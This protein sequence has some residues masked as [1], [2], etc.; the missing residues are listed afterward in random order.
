MRIAL[1]AAGLFLAG[2]GLFAH[3]QDFPTVKSGQWTGK[4]TSEYSG[5]SNYS[6]TSS[7]LQCLTGDE[8]KLDPTALFSDQTCTTNEM[9]VTDNKVFF[10]FSCN[11]GEGGGR[12][13]SS[14][15]ISTNTDR[16]A[17]ILSYRTTSY[18]ASSTTP[19]FYS[20]EKTLR[21]AGSV[22]LEAADGMSVE[23]QKAVAEEYVSNKEYTIAVEWLKKTVD[24]GDP[25]GQAELGFAYAYGLGVDQDFEEAMR[26]GLL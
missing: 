11:R 19:S 8:T 13:R 18:S 5:F 22:C 21:H 1:A 6:D 14:G 16:D 20:T 7:T 12:S 2:G 24:A 10:S 3:A 9:T 17:Y 26:L 15:T 25:E 23:L 4:T